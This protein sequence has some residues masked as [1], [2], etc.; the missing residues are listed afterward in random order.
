MAKRVQKRATIATPQTDEEADAWMRD[1]A[2][3]N[4]WLRG[5]DAELAE[6]SQELKQTYEDKAKPKRTEKA[7]LEAGIFAWAEANRKRLT[8]NG[9]TKT[10]KMASGEVKWRSLPAK[11]S[12]RGVDAVLAHLKANGLTRF[13]RRKESVDKEAMLRDPDAVKDVPGV[14]IGSGG[15]TIDIVPFELSLEES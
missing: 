2:K 11:V 5:V 12:L 4:N 8:K 14:K 9:R 1:I 3:I 6:K 7:Q 15:E 13:V 10:A